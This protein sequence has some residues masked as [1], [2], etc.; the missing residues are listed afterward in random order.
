VS[1][2]PDYSARELAASS[3]LSVVPEKRRDQVIDACCSRTLEKNEFLW[4]FGDDVDGMY[5]IES[6]CFRVETLESQHGSSM[7]T[8]FHAGSWIGEAELLANTGR[9]TTLCALRA[10]SL[11]FLPRRDF[12]AMSKEFPELWRGLGYLA[13]EHLYL[14]VASMHDMSI[15]SSSERMAAILLRIC[16]AR[17]PAFSGLVHTDLDVTQTELGQLCNVSRS[18]ISTLLSNFETQGL[19]RMQ[20][21]RITILDI[22]ALANEAGVTLAEDKN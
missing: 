8:I 15:R 17:V 6:G 13:A 3:W 14:A 10:T 12:M 21:G 20:Y 18:V 5:F 2:S 16:G 1:N 22:K 11:L 7:L 19:I 4:H 9:I